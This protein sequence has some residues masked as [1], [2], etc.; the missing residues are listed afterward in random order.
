MLTNNQINYLRK[1]LTGHCTS[2]IQT[3][4]EHLINVLTNEEGV[5]FVLLFHESSSSNSTA[6]HKDCHNSLPRG[7]PKNVG[8]IVAIHPQL[9]GSCQF[10]Q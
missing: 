7:H 2:P 10:K 5:D 1:L 6:S 4:A 8:P 9:E 3:A